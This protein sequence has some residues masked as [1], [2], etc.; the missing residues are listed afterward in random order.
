M[1]KK[2]LAVCLASLLG[3]GW[4]DSAQATCKDLQFPGCT[5]CPAGV[6]VRAARVRG[7][8]CVPCSHSYCEKE[9]CESQKN[10]RLSP[11]K[12]Q[13]I[14]EKVLR[15][16]EGE[17]L[18]L[19]GNQTIA[20]EIAKKN[21]WA[22]ITFLALYMGPNTASSSSPERATA[23]GIK[24]PMDVDI[25]SDMI[26]A[27]HEGREDPRNSLITGDSEEKI[28]VDYEVRKNADGSAYLEFRV[29]TADAQYR[30]IEKILPNV[31]LQLRR[32]ENEPDGHWEPIGW[33]EY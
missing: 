28:R 13:Q 15:D 9:E 21:T 17:K 10:S 4:I 32:V 6:H 8:V 23:W 12:K 24:K 14:I 5:A 33:E 18:F 3:A 1:R 26:N 2:F 19:S 7:G 27:H 31:R 22:A 29:S 25:A 16:S 20:L 30:E 11:S